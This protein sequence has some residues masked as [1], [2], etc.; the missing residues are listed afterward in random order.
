MKFTLRSGRPYARA[1]G[2]KPRVLEESVNGQQ[3]PVIQVDGNDRVILDVDYE[4]ET[5]SGRLNLYHSLDVR[6]T[7]YPRWWGLQW[8]V[9]LDVQNVYNRENQQQLNYYIDGDGNLRERPIN[10]IPLFPSLG[11]SVSF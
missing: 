11:L 7:T 5:Y 10:G 9:Y 6:I 2:V 8:S 4:D 1:V 3:V